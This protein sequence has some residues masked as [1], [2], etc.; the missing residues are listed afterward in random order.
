MF[1]VVTSSPEAVIAAAD[2]R[3][4]FKIMWDAGGDFIKE[5]R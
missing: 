5:V 4:F 3:E 1:S 2:P